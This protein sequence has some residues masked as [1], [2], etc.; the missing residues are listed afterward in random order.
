MLQNHAKFATLEENLR[1][2]AAFKKPKRTERQ[3]VNED[4]ELNVLLSV[5][6]NTQIST[7]EIAQNIGM[8]DRTVHTILKKHK[9]K[10]YIPQ[11]ITRWREMIGVED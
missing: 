7:R 1:N 6:K 3:F 10:P 4:V 5:A 11:K 2:Y 8:L 9:I